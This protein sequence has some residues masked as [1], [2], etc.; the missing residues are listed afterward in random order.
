MT[1]SKAGLRVQLGNLPPSEHPA[2]KGTE[3]KTGK[4]DLF[5]LDIS[6]PLGILDLLDILGLL[7]TLDLLRPFRSLDHQTILAPFRNFVNWTHI[8]FLD[9][10]E[11]LEEII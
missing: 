6:D 10:L 5:Q 11:L 8:D 1:S 9:L 3:I 2:T 4:Q 7:D